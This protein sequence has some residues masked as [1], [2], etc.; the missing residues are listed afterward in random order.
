MAQNLSYL[1]PVLDEAH[2]LMALTCQ[3]CG[4]TTRPVWVSEDGGDDLVLRVNTHH[5]PTCR[6]SVTGEHV[7]RM[8]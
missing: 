8:H 7:M 4:A 6:L 1:I 2:H 5:E 3:Y